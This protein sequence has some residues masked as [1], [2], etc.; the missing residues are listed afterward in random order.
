MRVLAHRRGLDQALLGVD[1]ETFERL[2][3]SAPDGADGV[4]CVPFLTGERSPDLPL[5]TGS[6]LGLAPGQRRPSP[7][8]ASAD[9]GADQADAREHQQ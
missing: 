4:L 5:A 8:V 1:L 3:S 2:V 7:V 9:R 6:Y